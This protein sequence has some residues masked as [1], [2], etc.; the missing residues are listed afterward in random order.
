MLITGFTYRSVASQ[1]ILSYSINGNINNTTGISSFGLSGDNGNLNLFTF[2]TG[3]IYDVNN[4][5]VWSYN[6]SENFTISGNINTGDH[7]YYIN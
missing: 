1:N 2:R 5:H 4:R 3:K 7:H 6:P